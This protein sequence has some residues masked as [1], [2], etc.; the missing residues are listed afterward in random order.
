[1][2]STKSKEIYFISNACEEGRLKTQKLKLFAKDAGFDCTQNI[3]QA[4]FILF[5]ACGH[6]TSHEHDAKQIIK[7][8]WSKRKKRLDR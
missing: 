6:L 5:N 2:H 1:M 7:K 4:E 8:I 3:S